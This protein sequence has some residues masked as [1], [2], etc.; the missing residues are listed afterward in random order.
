MRQL[1]EKRTPPS[2]GAEGGAAERLNNV[3]PSSNNTVAAQRQSGSPD[4]FVAVV[5]KGASSQVRVTLA[6]WRGQGKVSVREFAPG[7]IAGTFWPTAKGA[8]IDV[9]KL[10]EL[11]KALQAAEAQARDGGLLPQGRAL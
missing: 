4:L 11:I 10:P 7:A 2:L 5:E 8:T 3:R 9:D 6:K 1:P